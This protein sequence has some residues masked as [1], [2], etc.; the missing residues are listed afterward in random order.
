MFGGQGW[1]IQ[2]TTTMIVYKGLISSLKV[3]PFGSCEVDNS[4][5]GGS[6]GLGIDGPMSGRRGK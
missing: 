2:M 6:T 4:N 1:S 5:D 3:S